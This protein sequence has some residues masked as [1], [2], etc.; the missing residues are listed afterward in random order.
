MSDA[1]SF[2]IPKYRLHKPTGLGLV[3]I[4]GRDFYL[5]TERHKARRRT[6]ASSPSGSRTIGKSL[7]CLI[8]PTRHRDS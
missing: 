3:R 1:R 8:C 4:R 2:K 5:G 7:R 6:V